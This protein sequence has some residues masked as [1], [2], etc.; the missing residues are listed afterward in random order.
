MV[1]PNFGVRTLFRPTRLYALHARRIFPETN[2]HKW[3]YR[4]S[5]LSLLQYSP[6]FRT[7]DR[8]CAQ[9]QRLPNPIQHPNPVFTLHDR[10]SNYKLAFRLLR[11]S[12][13]S[14]LYNVLK[15][16]SFRLE[17]PGFHRG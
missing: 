9:V 5:L 7:K 17:K 12:I 2:S 8:L 11:H 3:N 6:I 14:H 10:L 16:H 1:D 4:R 13:Y 15:S